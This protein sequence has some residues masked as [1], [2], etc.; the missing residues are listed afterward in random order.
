[1]VLVFAFSLLHFWLS[2]LPSHFYTFNIFFFLSKKKKKTQKKKNPK[3]RKKNSNKG[4][5][6]LSIFRFA[7]SFLAPTFALSFQALSPNIFFFS[8]KKKKKKKRKKKPKRRKKIT[9]KR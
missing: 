7:F 1:L 2:F 8:K 3:R 4:R 5:S 6:L 9:K